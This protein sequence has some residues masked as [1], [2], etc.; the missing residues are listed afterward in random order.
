MLHTYARIIPLG[1]NLRII[2]SQSS[3]QWKNVRIWFINKRMIYWLHIPLDDAVDW[4][5][6]IGQ[7]CKSLLD[8]KVERVR[9]KRN[10]F[11]R[12]AS[13]F[14]KADQVQKTSRRFIQST[15]ESGSVYS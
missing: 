9:K 15:M 2:K 12:A 11:E 10:V 1:S 13:A 5:P 8:T 4:D 7:F 14:E 6:N 3:E